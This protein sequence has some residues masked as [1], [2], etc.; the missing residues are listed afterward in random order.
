MKI[1]YFTDFFYPIVGGVT[2]AIANLA[3]QMALHGHE[4]Y[5][6]AP[7]WKHNPYTIDEVKNL[8]IEYV[9]SMGT[10]IPDFQLPFSLHPGMYNRLRSINPDIIHLESPVF[11]GTTGLI[12]ARLMKKPVIIT[13]HGYFMEPMY[14]KKAGLD[15]LGM[16]NNQTIIQMGWKF[17][18]FYYNLADGI[19]CPSEATK[20]DLIAHG[21]TKPVEAISNGVNTILISDVKNNKIPLKK[22]FELPKK[23][24][25][26]VGRLS[27]EKSM[28]ILMKAYIQF[29]KKNSDVDLV[30]VGD[31]PEKNE[32]MGMIKE[33]NLEKRVH[34]LGNVD[35]DILLRSNIYRDAV[36]FIT[37]SKSETQCICGLEAIAFGLPMIGINSRAIPELIKE[38]GVLCSPDNIDEL[39]KGMI[40]IV[41]NPEE[42]ERMS[43]A[44]LKL[45]AEHALS[46]TAS[47]MEHFYKK[48]IDTKVTNTPTSL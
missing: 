27:D 45:A 14:L 28:D 35:N 16:D 17:A 19:T 30:L 2:I 4:A 21:F 22:E 9:N 26:Y 25:V 8:H 11:L 31:G 33:N 47:K 32:I 44:S 7:K 48:I 46:N 38:N 41:N 3:T 20:K 5:V 13:F 10:G 42:R 36:A 39:E 37:A 24:F 1:V 40:F 6:F 12:F 43:Q 23:Y 18:Q 15:K 29:S 34:V